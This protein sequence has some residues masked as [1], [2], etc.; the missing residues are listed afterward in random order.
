[1]QQLTFDNSWD[2]LVGSIFLIAQESKEN[3]AAALKE[4]ASS[5]QRIPSSLGDK[6]EGEVAVKKFFSWFK[7]AAAKDDTFY[8]RILELPLLQALRVAEDNTKGIVLEETE[9]SSAQ[10]SSEDPSSQAWLQL[11]RA[12]CSLNSVGPAGREIDGETGIPL[13]TN[14]EIEEFSDPTARLLAQS[15]PPLS[16]KITER[17]IENIPSGYATSFSPL[18]ASSFEQM[19][20]TTGES[21]RSPIFVVP[22]CWALTVHEDKNIGPPSPMNF[23]LNPAVLVATQQAI[24]WHTKDGWD[25]IPYEAPLSEDY[26][27]PYRYRWSVPD[28]AS[29]FG[30]GPF[31]EFQ[32]RHLFES[33]PETNPELFDMFLLRAQNVVETSFGQWGVPKNFLEVCGVKSAV[34]KYS[35]GLGLFEKLHEDQGLISQ[36]K[37]AFLRQIDV[38]GT[39]NKSLPDFFDDC[40]GLFP[41]L[42][43]FV[44]A[45]GFNAFMP[46]GLD[47]F[48]SEL[49]RFS[50]MTLSFSMKAKQLG[51][52]EGDDYESPRDPLGKDI[53]GF[54]G[55]RGATLPMFIESAANDGGGYLPLL[56]RGLA[57]WW[58]T[59]N[60]CRELP[61]MVHANRGWRDVTSATELVSGNLGGQLPVVEPRTKIPIPTDSLR[62]SWRSSVDC[63]DT[64]AAKEMRELLKS[65]NG[66]ALAWRLLATNLANKV[67]NEAEVL[68][69]AREAGEQSVTIDPCP[70]NLQVLAGILEQQGDVEE[71]GELMKQAYCKIAIPEYSAES[72]VFM[73]IREQDSLSNLSEV[74]NHIFRE[75][76]AR[77]LTHEVSTHLGLETFSSR[78]YGYPLGEGQSQWNLNTW[79]DDLDCWVAWAVNVA[80]G[81]GDKDLAKEYIAKACDIFGRESVRELDGVKFKSGLI[82]S[83]L[84]AEQAT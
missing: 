47:P 48:H 31:A 13:F 57:G 65:D 38:S 15:M 23:F 10:L 35:D 83:L 24:Y 42:A 53:K 71:S 80:F 17:N 19:F 33:L 58:E 6:A 9:R 11:V 16:P 14:E 5:V 3:Y 49:F 12:S 37:T 55:R 63:H 30:G 56:L 68:Q 78:R 60:A 50:D 21:V 77:A 22:R 79:P 2:I 27:D 36:I 1:M 51:L 52:I 41:Y 4:A 45:G 67:E 40:R 8:P 29:I 32:H 18:P 73:K 28:F 20:A 76:V 69:Q 64:F 43:P 70:R 7:E 72:L 81:V 46:R 74:P 61:V 26:H 54:R 34:D 75:G 82:E 39:G 59:V 44:V 25:S 84:P 62:K 66:N